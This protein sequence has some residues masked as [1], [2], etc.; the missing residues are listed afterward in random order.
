[1][2][3]MPSS[4]TAGLKANSSW[5]CLAR[6][7]TAACESELARVAPF[8][9]IWPQ[10]DDSLLV[11]QYSHDVGSLAGP[12]TTIA[13]ARRSVRLVVGERNHLPWVAA[14]AC[15]AEWGSGLCTQ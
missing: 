9:R 13:A 5:K 15:L 8:I 7:N 14:V 4:G 11:D 1:M 2:M 10:A 6:L 3:P 12:S